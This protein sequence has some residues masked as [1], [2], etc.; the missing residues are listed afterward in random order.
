MSYKDSLEW[1][2]GGNYTPEQVNDFT[3]ILSKFASQAW[4]EQ[5]HLLEIMKWFHEEGKFVCMDKEDVSMEIEK[6][7]VKEE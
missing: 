7:L 5:D 6:L 4:L 1:L 3:A 2:F